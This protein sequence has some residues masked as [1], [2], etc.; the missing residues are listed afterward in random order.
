M[1]EH[2]GGVDMGGYIYGLILVGV[3]AAVV[4]LLAV[5]KDASRTKG[6]VRL[7]AGLC[8]LVAC[9]SPL[10]EGVAYLKDMADGEFALDLPQGSGEGN[11]Y[12][13]MFDG[14]L[15][16]TGAEEIGAWVGSILTDTF[17]I[18]AEHSEIEVRMTVREGVPCPDE[19]YISLWGK[20][21]IKN[22][23]QI[24]DYISSRLSCACYVSVG[25]GE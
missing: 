20:A 2:D 21:I 12:Q 9:I 13:D 10:R 1:A 5:G 8:V 18:S 24:E 25:R 4:E 22:P 17:G 7:M 23:H 15:S 14:Y 16:N 19:I 11:H 3:V 6:Y